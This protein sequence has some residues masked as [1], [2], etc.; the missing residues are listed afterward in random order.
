MCPKSCIPPA[1]PSLAASGLMASSARVSSEAA[2]TAAASLSLSCRFYNI[3]HPYDPVAYRIEPLIDRALQLKKPALVDHHAGKRLVHQIDELKESFED[4]IKTFK[5]WWMDSTAP[6]QEPVLKN[7]LAGIMLN[8][9]E[10]IDYVL[11]V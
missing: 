8:R 6:P 2:A 9:E 1:C 11:Q 10:R 7:S 5:R 4:K 3:F